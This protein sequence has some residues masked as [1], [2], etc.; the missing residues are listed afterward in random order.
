MK[1]YL[2]VKIKS[3]AAEAGIIRFEERRVKAWR[4][5]A[6]ARQAPAERIES[7]GVELAGLHNHRTREVRKE[8][9]AALLAYAYLRRRPY[10]VVEPPASVGIDLHRIAQLVTRYGGEAP[11]EK[12]KAAVEAWL[13][14]A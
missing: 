10:A 11:V 7:L 13:K 14:A 2:K 1:S 6:T 12:A 5:R 3:L 8:Q 9:R 4:R